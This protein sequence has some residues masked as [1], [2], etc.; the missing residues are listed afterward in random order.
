MI[1]ILLYLVERGYIPNIFIKK[2]VL[3]ISRRRL[4]ESQATKEK[5]KFI[6]Y[7]SKGETA[8]KTFDANNQH[9]EVPPKFFK[10]V[11]GERLKY[12]CSLFEDDISLDEAEVKML[13]LYI[14]RGE[15]RD[16]QRI[17]DLGCGW[18]SFSIYVA[19]KFPS[20][21]ITSVSNSFD[22]IEFINSEA[23]KKNLTNLNA[24]K[25]DVNHLNLKDKFDRVIS[26]EM[27][28]HLRN[29]KSILASLRYLLNDNGKLFIH[30]FCNKKIA[31]LYEVKSELD[32]MTKFFFLGGI[33][34]CKDIFNYFTED[35]V[36]KKQWDVEG[37]HYSNTS[38]EWFK[39]H[40]T[41]KK[42]II[43]IFREHYDNPVVWYYRWKIFFLTCEVFFAIDNGREYFVSHY[44]L[45]KV[46]P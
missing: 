22:Q 30:I 13:D 26:I 16:G 3:F 14:K 23:K 41:N 27:F 46:D 1:K 34:P 45:E 28:E 7:I 9:Y 4:A 12:S 11:L 20:A 8:E 36:V 5:E 6:N 15:I 37:S 42:E 29:Y 24:I 19:E 21:K 32:W 43:E 35:F 2:A 18:G 10:H 17:L 44:L 40:C 33:M 31:Y 25:M 39:K 38:K